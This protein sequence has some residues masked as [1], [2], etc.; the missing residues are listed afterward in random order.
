MDVATFEEESAV[1]CFNLGEDGVSVYGPFVDD[2][3]A[4]TFIACGP[5]GM[6]EY[7]SYATVEVLYP[8]HALRLDLTGHEQLLDVSK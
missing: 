3:E 4:R 1:V 2:E 7:L 8:P 5:H 6:E